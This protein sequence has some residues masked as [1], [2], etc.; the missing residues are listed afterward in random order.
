MSSSPIKGK[1]ARIKLPLVS[2]NVHRT[3]TKCLLLFIN[4]ILPI[5][6]TLPDVIKLGSSFFTLLIESSTS[7]LMWSIPITFPLGPT[8]KSIEGGNSVQFTQEYHNITHASSHSMLIDW[9]ANESIRIPPKRNRMCLPVMCGSPFVRSKRTGFH[10]RS[11]RPE[12]WLPHT[13]GHVEAL[14]RRHAGWR[15][16]RQGNCIT[17]L[18]I[19]NASNT[20]TVSI[21]PS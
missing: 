1:T 4:D 3:C 17:T 15:G 13:A 6:L 8:C 16:R 14:G 9:Q 20:V 12:L 18:L 21:P 10:Y 5:S 19:H 11:R 2:K 7:S